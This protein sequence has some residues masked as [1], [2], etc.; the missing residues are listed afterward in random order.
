M[1]S[2][3]RNSINIVLVW[4]LVALAP[5]KALDQ[6]NSG[7]KEDLLNRANPGMS[8]QC[9]N[10]M[11]NSRSYLDAAG[12]FGALMY[13]ATAAAL[14]GA[15]S[16]PEGTI[17]L[18]DDVQQGLAAE[19]RHDYAQALKFYEQAQKK[20][21]VLGTALL[22]SLYADGHG[23]LKNKQRAKIYFESGL[24][25]YKYYHKAGRAGASAALG[26]ITAGLGLGQLYDQ[27]NPKKA[28]KIYRRI[29]LDLGFSIMQNSN[30]PWALVF[31]WLVPITG[32]GLYPFMCWMPY[33]IGLKYM[34]PTD[35][36][37]PFARQLISIVLYKIGMAYKDGRGTG[38]KLHKAEKFLKKA[39]DFGNDRALEVLRGFSR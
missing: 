27:S 4:V 5:L 11:S 8:A 19:D 14:A 29:L 39:A 21:E 17:R 1:F 38:V 18:S 22:G 3:V 6:V 23:V 37:S 9:Q 31:W 28:L 2:Y 30:S 34:K 25:N 33:V 32:G 12:H 36:P 20:G 15:C 13:F 16:D 10:A 26:M 24:K 35:I 7:L